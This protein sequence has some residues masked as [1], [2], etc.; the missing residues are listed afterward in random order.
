M[1]IIF[2]TESIEVLLRAS[3]LREAQNGTQRNLTSRQCSLC[4]MSF[5]T[6]KSYPKQTCGLCRWERAKAEGC[7]ISTYLKA[8]PGRTEEEFYADSIAQG[9][10]LQR[11]KERTMKA[12]G[13]TFHRV[14][15]ERI[16]PFAHLLDS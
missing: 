3:E 14:L 1:T 4:F 15:S 8:A 16:K 13:V 11:R 9:I 5:Q 2:K 7:E 10:R 6:Y 12:K